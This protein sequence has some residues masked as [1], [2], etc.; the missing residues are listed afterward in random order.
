MKSK[1]KKTVRKQTGNKSSSDAAFL[2]RLIQKH[3]TGD[4]FFT[5]YN[6][7]PWTVMTTRIKRVAASCLSQDETSGKR[8]RSR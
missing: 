8:K 7:T 3:P 1:A 6:T 2:L 4:F 5:D